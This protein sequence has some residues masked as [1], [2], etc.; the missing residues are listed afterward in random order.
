MATELDPRTPLSSA[1]HFIA[2]GTSKCPSCLRR[3]TRLPGH[4]R[5]V[6]TDDDDFDEDSIPG[7]THPQAP[8][9]PLSAKPP[10]PLD[11]GKGRAPDTL[12]PPRAA[13]PNG[14]GSSSPSNHL[15]GNIGSTANS[16]APKG[17]RRTVGGVRIET[18]WVPT[19]H[20]PVAIL[21]FLSD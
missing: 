13:T 3:V 10:P 4:H 2:A 20:G 9:P 12:L 5:S 1:Q 6:G 14:I 21:V 18:R 7:F 16:A 11:K 8:D 15:A 19:R 17:D